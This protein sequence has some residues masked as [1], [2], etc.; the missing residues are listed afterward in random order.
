MADEFGGK[1]SDDPE[2]LWNSPDILTPSPGVVE[3]GVRI[4]ARTGGDVMPMEWNCEILIG[5]RVVKQIPSGPGLQFF[6]RLTPHNLI[7]GGTEFWFRIEYWIPPFWSRWANSGNMIMDLGKCEILLPAENSTIS[8]FA[9][10][11]GKGSPKTRVDLYESD[12]GNV[13]YGTTIVDGDGNWNATPDIALPPGL[14]RLIALQRLNGLSKWSNVVGYT[15]SE[16][17]PVPPPEITTPKTGE[18]LHYRDT[19]TGTGIPNAM[20]LLYRQR[21]GEIIYGI[22]QVD[23]HGDWSTPLSRDVQAGP[24][25]I[26]AVQVVSG[27]ISD[28]STVV[29]FTIVH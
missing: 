3:P 28:Y 11:S 20:V 22:A 24:F 15:V 7:P 29:H 27:A 14:F 10:I 2:V 17:E 18:F 23:E 8:P 26:T 16:L 21:D 4:V 25:S 12:V 5:N 19:L 9:M 13:R 6:H 1:G